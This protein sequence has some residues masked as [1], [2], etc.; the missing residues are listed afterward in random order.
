M[1]NKKTFS[2]SGYNFFAAG[3][4]YGIGNFLSAYLVGNL[5]W[6]PFKVGILLGLANL[7]TILLL[8]PVG[9]LVDSYARKIRSMFVL[10][11]LIIGIGLFSYIKLT[12]MNIALI[13][14]LLGAAVALLPIAIASLTA[15]L[16]TQTQFSRQTGINQISNRLGNMAFVLLIAGLTQ[17]FN[18]RFFLLNLSVLSSFSLIFL[19]TLKQE[20]LFYAN[21]HQSKEL[22]SIKKIA[23]LFQQRSLM[24]FTLVTVLYHLVHASMGITLSEQVALRY[25]THKMGYISD[26][27]L[28][29]E[30]VSILTTALVCRNINHWNHS[31]IFL[32]SLSLLTLQG[33][34]YLVITNFTALLVMQVIEGIGVGISEYMFILLVAKMTQHLGIFNVAQGFIIS[35]QWL[36]VLVGKIII[37]YVVNSL[38]FNAAYIILILISL[39]ACVLFMVIPALQQLE[40]DNF[41]SHLMQDISV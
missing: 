11:T 13:Q 1:N 32:F 4:T 22:I 39:L 3:A 9:L 30:I 40:P 20:N 23:I 19:F 36:G 34:Y 33:C 15:D 16:F 5:G 35:L 17:Y 38:G 31:R 25:T 26:M 6:N 7:S 41:S 21:K 27:L 37:G 8:I 10:L 2:L 28:V 24:M 29:I 18:E 14:L 12:L